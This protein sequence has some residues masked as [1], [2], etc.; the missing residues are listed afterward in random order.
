MSRLKVNLGR[1][2]TQ[3][4]H[5]F[6]DYDHLSE[7]GLGYCLICGGITPK[8]ELV[9][10][11]CLRQKVENPYICPICGRHTPS[12]GFYT[13]HYRLTHGHPMILDPTFPPDPVTPTEAARVKWAAYKN[14]V[15]PPVPMPQMEASP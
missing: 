6:E 10:G 12:P 13:R 8:S 1:T 9:D 7:Y 14:Q 4:V 5:P 2:G 3:P 11:V 15:S